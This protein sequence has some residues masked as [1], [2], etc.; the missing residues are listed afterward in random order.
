MLKLLQQAVHLL[1]V[2]SATLGDALAAAAVDGVGV[3]AF[4]GC[5]RVDDGL[6]AL[7]GVVVDVEVLDLLAHTGYHAHEVL[8]VTHLLDLGYLGEEV[9]EVKL[10]ACQLLGEL[11]GLFLVEL[12]LCLLHERYDV[13]HAED[14]VGHA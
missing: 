8:D 12:L 1:Y 10:V 9:V 5:H 7:E 6:Y 14:T 11:L 3:A 4:I 2:G 13:A